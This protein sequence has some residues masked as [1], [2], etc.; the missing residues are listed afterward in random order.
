LSIQHV[1]L[2]V[3]K[4][5]FVKFVWKKKALL[6]GPKAKGGFDL[7]YFVDLNIYF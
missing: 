6:S 5:M 4:S 3:K 1:I 2:H 7:L